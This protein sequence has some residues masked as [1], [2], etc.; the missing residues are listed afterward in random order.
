MVKN[1]ILLIL[2][3]VCFPAPASGQEP[4][5]GDGFPI[6]FKE[7]AFT[8]VTQ[9]ASFGPRS[10]GAEGEKLAFDYICRQF[11]EAGFEVQVETFEYETFK[12]DRVDFMVC[13]AQIE[14]VTIGFNPYSG[15]TAFDGT[16]LWVSPDLTGD[17]LNQLDMKDK[18]VVTTTPL[19][20]FALMFRNP[21]AIVYIGNSDFAA[22][23]EKDCAVCELSIAGTLETH[24]SKNIIAELPSKTAN[25]GEV[26]I[27]AHWDSYRGSPGADDNATGVGI[28]LELGRFFSTF[29]GD[30]ARTIKFVSF[31]AEEL[32]MLGAR[33]YLDS[34]HDDLQDCILVFNIDKVGGPN[35]PS[36]EMLGGIQGVP[37]RMGTNQ[38]PTQVHNRTFEALDGRWRIIDPELIETFT[39]TNKPTWLVETIEQ[40]ARQLGIEIIPRGNMGA[41]QQVFTQA[42][43]VATSIGTWGNQSHTANDVPAQINKDM[44]DNVGK[45]VASV[46]LTSIHGG[47]TE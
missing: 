42:G 7:R 11:E 30:I 6:D 10:P 37:Q 24:T 26:I 2:C 16:P 9:L 19:D 32:G 15:I 3:L 40:S 27:S 39:I 12:I 44:L 4:A 22:L 25:A 34:H 47:S 14:P 20:Y 1:S 18:I 35:G 21:R 8:H 17:E 29:Q 33:A 28:L 23:A 31:G 46:V 38:F 45:L 13:G 36:V 41:D 5:I 43:I